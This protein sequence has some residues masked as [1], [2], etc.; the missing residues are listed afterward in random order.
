MILKEMVLDS[1][2]DLSLGDQRRERR[3]RSAA[4]KL[5]TN[6]GQTLPAK[7][8]SPDELHAFY[9]LMDCDEVTHDEFVQCARKATYRKMQGCDVVLLASDT[10][11]LDYSGL[12]A[13]AGLGSV[14]DGNG[15]G[16]LAHNTLA[17]TPEGET[18]GL[19]NQIL[20]TRDAPSDAK[21]PKSQT[22]ADPKLE[23]R[24]WRNAVAEL[25]EAPEG[26]AV[27]D[28]CDRGADITEFLAHEHAFGRNFLVRSQHN[29]KVR[30]PLEN[31]GSDADSDGDKPAYRQRKLHDHIRS[32]AP[33]EAARQTLEVPVRKGGRVVGKRTAKLAVA[34]TKVEIIP[35]RQRR[36][37]H[38]REPIPAWA[39]RVW[40]P[41][42][43]KNQDPLEWLLLTNVPVDCVADA[44]ERV[45]WYRRRWVVEELHK[46]M[47]TGLGVENLQLETRGRLDP[48]IALYTIVATLLLRLRDAARR[49]ESAEIRAVDWL[50]ELWIH[51]LQTALWEKRRRVDRSWTIRDFLRGL[52]RLGGHQGR[53]GDGPPGWLTLWRG[54]SE[55]HTLLRF[56]KIYQASELW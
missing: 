4:R 39:V 42:P 40:E 56:T 3:T 7:M 24:L 23:S 6:R 49:P 19:A 31:T 30:L 46:G 15:R 32:L 36:G 54:W 33:S 44:W 50:P 21:R 41:N 35:P 38:G 29:R 37:E 48:A 10:S 47:K 25:P 5:A 28:V 45:D 9:R 14:G 55:F 12:H 22:A 53:K 1:F 8:G 11:T 27:V 17:V 13:N 26:C 2:E 51:V 20:H 18:L 16:V 34:W 43:P 52:A